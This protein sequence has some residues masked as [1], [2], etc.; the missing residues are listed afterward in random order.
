MSWVRDTEIVVYE[1]GYLGWQADR[2]IVG[3]EG[4]GKSM[5]GSFS[6]HT[7]CVCHCAASNV[8]LRKLVDQ[9]CYDE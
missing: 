6:L 4:R 9:H 2:Q 1:R 8:C 3:G 7:K 5:L